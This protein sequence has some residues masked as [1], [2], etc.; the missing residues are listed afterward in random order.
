MP[1]TPKSEQR[2]RGE[3]LFKEICGA[4]AAPMEMEF[5]DITIEHI[6]GEVWAREDISNRDQRLLTIAVLT[7]LGDQSS[8]EIHMKMALSSG[9]LSE[10]E[11]HAAVI[12][13]AHYAGWPR[14]ASAFLVAGK[15]IAAHRAETS[16]NAG[17]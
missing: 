7:T 1:Q 8:L 17:E 10:T 4:P 3:R 11:L 9:D 2:V 5:L 6:F 15:A 13:L 16:A 12:H 14:G